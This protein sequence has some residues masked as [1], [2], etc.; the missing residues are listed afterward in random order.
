MSND[1]KSLAHTRWNCSIILC[2]HQNIEE[3]NLW[4]VKAGYWKNTEKMC[5]M[6]EIEIIEAHAMPTIS[7]CW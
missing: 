2:L 5:E 4:S 3:S 7:I 6:K 1:D